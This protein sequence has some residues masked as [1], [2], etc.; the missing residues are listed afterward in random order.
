VSEG[1]ASQSTAGKQGKSPYM[2]AF[3]SFDSFFPSS[4]CPRRGGQA[5]A[6]ITT[7]GGRQCSPL[8]GTGITSSRRTGKRRRYH[9]GRGAESVPDEVPRHGLLLNLNIFRFLSMS[10]I[11]SF[12]RR[13]HHQ[14]GSHR[15]AKGALSHFSLL[16][17]KKACRKH[18]RAL[19]YPLCYELI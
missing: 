15:A 17:L 7:T 3:I 2:S 4:A 18:A 8:T 10:G 13:E 5:N 19:L 1:A 16:Q 6:V 12:S 9:H 14:R 11:S